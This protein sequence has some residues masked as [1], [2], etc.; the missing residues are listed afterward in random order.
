MATLFC[1]P[2]DDPK[3]GVN[4]SPI[5]RLVGQPLTWAQALPPTGP[6]T[7]LPGTRRCWRHSG[8]MGSSPRPASKSV[9]EPC[10]GACAR[11]GGG[12]GQARGPGFPPPRGALPGSVLN[13]L[14]PRSV[15]QRGESGHGC[16][17]P[18]LPPCGES[19]GEGSSGVWLPCFHEC[20]WGLRSRGQ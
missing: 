19:E 11:G 10:P 18:P 7:F 2:M 9:L 17:G 13:H 3:T 8:I 1:P 16:W 6:Q 5:N 15:A 14:H 12:Q 4:D 20:P